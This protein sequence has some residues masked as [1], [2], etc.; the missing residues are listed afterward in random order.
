MIHSQQVLKRFSEAASAYDGAARLQQ[1]RAWR[2][3]KLC[4]RSA[5]PKGLWVD[6]GSGTG[7]LADALESCHP[8]QRVLRL[9]GSE[10]ML[11]RQPGAW[12]LKHDLSDGLPD[13]SPAP[14]LLASS[15]AL[16]WLPDPARELQRWVTALPNQGWLALAV[17]IA[18]S[19]PQ[20]RHA[21]DQSNQVCSAFTLPQREEL[22]KAIAPGVIDCEECLNFT[23][24]AQRPVDLLK[25]MT[26]IGASITD[27]GRLT[28]GGWRQL[29]KAWPRERSSS[30]FALTW[31][32]L[33]L[34][35]RR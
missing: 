32:M 10:A 23:Q 18:G 24:R 7:R 4:Q 27:N 14:Q 34:M 29:L 25:P 19:F 22:V 21:A 30:A 2:L 20:W 17:P 1:A 11:S 16:H 15:F 3:A 12:T 5:I 35:V 33:V 8:G 26:T 31:R 28:A 13:W 6:L 9:D